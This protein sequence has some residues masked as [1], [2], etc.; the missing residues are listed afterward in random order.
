VIEKEGPTI[1]LDTKLK[2]LEYNRTS[3]DN[4]KQMYAYTKYYQSSH[5]ALV[6]PGNGLENCT[7]KFLPERAEFCH[8]PCSII[9][10]KIPEKMEGILEWQ[11]QISTTILKSLNF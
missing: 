2:V 11:Q 9:R 3:D 7:G 6:Y 4:L 10:I 8:S 5:T 1:I